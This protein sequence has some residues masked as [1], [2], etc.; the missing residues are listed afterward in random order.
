MF[1]TSSQNNFR[2][3]IYLGYSTVTITFFKWKY[4]SLSLRRNVEIKCAKL[5]Q[6]KILQLIFKKKCLQGLTWLHLPFFQR[7][8]G[9]AGLEQ[10]LVALGF[11]SL[12]R[13]SL[14]ALLPLTQCTSLP[15]TPRPQV[16]EHC[17]GESSNQ[18]T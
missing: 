2:N 17:Q 4:Y 9:Q 12:H 6:M 16:A 15:C 13:V 1:C 8:L 10:L 14:T 5:S 18:F 11:S 3:N 7:Y